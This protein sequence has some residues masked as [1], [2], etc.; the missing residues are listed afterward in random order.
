M[1]G[2]TAAQLEALAKQVAQARALLPGSNTTDVLSHLPPSVVQQLEPM[3]VYSCELTAQYIFVVYGRTR[4]MSQV[5]AHA[6]SRNEQVK[7]HAIR[8]YSELHRLFFN[9]TTSNGQPLCSD[10]ERH[11][12]TKAAE[13]GW[14][15]E[16]QDCWGRLEGGL[17]GIAGSMTILRLTHWHQLVALQFDSPVFASTPVPQVQPSSRCWRRCA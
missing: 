17:L 12:A 16:C 11:L 4:F 1:Q 14:V 2:R 10:G 6:G 13:E 8:V 15:G 5:N 9:A 3:N 7:Q